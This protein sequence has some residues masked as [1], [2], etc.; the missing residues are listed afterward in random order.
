MKFLPGH[1]GTCKKHFPD[2]LRTT[3]PFM[4]KQGVEK[5]TMHLN[6]V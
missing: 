3:W 2:T 4:H 5:Q 1:S 6:S